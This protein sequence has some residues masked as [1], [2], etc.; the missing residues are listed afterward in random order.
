MEHD[1]LLAIEWFQ[2][3]TKLNQDK[4]HLLVSGYKHENVWVQIGDEK[5]WESN[6]EKLLDL[7]S[8]ASHLQTHHE[9]VGTDMK[10]GFL[11]AALC[12]LFYF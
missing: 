2:N 8:T 6:K 3:N 1:S 12:Q 11:Q 10:E 7:Q 4:C 5:I 9:A